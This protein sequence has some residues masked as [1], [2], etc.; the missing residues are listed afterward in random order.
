M[1]AET[2]TQTPHSPALW[3]PHPNRASELGEAFDNGFLGLST[4]LSLPSPAPFLHLQDPCQP[5]GIS[6]C[7]WPTAWSKPLLRLAWTN[8]L[9]CSLQPLHAQQPEGFLLP[10]DFEKL[11]TCT[12]VARTEQTPVQPLPRVIGCDILLHLL[13][14][15]VCMCTSL[16]LLS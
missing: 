1:G 11:Q 7:S 12:K 8:L 10:F 3:F 2:G 4:L 16:A 14:F 13:Y 6:S 5:T 9:Y 15:S